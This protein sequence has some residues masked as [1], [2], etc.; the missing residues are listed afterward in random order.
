MHKIFRQLTLSRIAAALFVAGLVLFITGLIGLL[1]TST[2]DAAMVLGVHGLSAGQTVL[3]GIA[4][5]VLAAV[6]FGLAIANE[7]L[8]RVEAK[9][10]AL[11]RKLDLEKQASEYLAEQ[12]TVVHRGKNN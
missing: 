3:L 4:S 10:D 12:S 8:V 6:V 9:L 11:A 7:R 1:A 2:S 5:F